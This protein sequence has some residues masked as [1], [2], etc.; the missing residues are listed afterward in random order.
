[1]TKLLALISLTT[2]LAACSQSSENKSYKDGFIDKPVAPPQVK[3]ETKKTAPLPR[4][5]TSCHINFPNSVRVPEIYFSEDCKTAFLSPLTEVESTYTV[6]VLSSTPSTFCADLSE[7]TKYALESKKRAEEIEARIQDLQATLTNTPDEA[8]KSTLL[9]KLKLLQEVHDEAVKDSK[10]PDLQRPALLANYIFTT[11]NSS[12]LQAWKDSNPDLEIMLLEV[13]HSV[14]EISSKKQFDASSPI[15]EINFPPDQDA[16]PP[17]G[18][19]KS[20][21]RYAI[22]NSSMLGFVSITAE[23]YCGS[24]QSTK[25]I[26]SDYVSIKLLR[27]AWARYNSGERFPI[28][29]TEVLE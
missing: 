4:S 26:F 6:N 22:F 15:A 13:P 1:M 11:G 27:K 14:L 23:V 17:F 18:V 9:Q 7:D 10:P 24:S 2:L 19:K 21:A 28:E 5:E 29:L 8:K 25:E 20:D 16:R 12:N 3:A